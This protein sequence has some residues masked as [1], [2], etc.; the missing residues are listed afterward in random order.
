MV[1]SDHGFKTF[2]RGINLNSWLLK[3]GYLVL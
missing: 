2:R 3:N 1:I